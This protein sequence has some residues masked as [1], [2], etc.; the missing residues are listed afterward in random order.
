[1][2]IEKKEDW[3]VPFA[4]EFFKSVTIPPIFVKLSIIELA[5]LGEEVAHCLED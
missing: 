2:P 3:L 5:D 4:I 1:M